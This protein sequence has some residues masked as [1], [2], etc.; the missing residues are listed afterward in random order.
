MATTVYLSVGDGATSDYLTLSDGTNYVFLPGT[1][2]AP[3]PV[4]GDQV[5]IVTFALDVL[6]STAD[7]MWANYRAILK[8]IRQAKQAAGA[9][10]RGTRVTLGVRMASATTM[11]YLDVIDGDAEIQPEAFDIPLTEANWARGVIVT[12]VCELYGRSASVALSVSGTITNDDGSPATVGGAGNASLYLPDIPGD[13]EAFCQIKLIDLSTGSTFLN[14]MRIGRRSRDAMAASTDFDPLLVATANSPG[15][16]AADATAIGGN[17]IRVTTTQAWQDL[18]DVAG[19]STGPNNSG[20]FDLW[21]IARNDVT[22][23]RPTLAIASQTS[24]SLGVGTFIMKVA[25]G[26]T[27]GSTGEA[28]DPVT[29]YTTAGPDDQFNLVTNVGG[30]PNDDVILYYKKGSAVWK[31]MPTDASGASTSF[32]NETSA[33]V[34]NPPTSSAFPLP[35]LRAQVGMSSGTTLYDLPAVSMSV[36]NSVWHPVYLGRVSLPPVPT[37]EGLTTERWKVTIQARSQNTTTPNADVCAMFLMP[38]DEP[39]M[40]ATYNGLALATLREWMLDSRRDERAFGILRSTADQTEQ[41]QLE[42]LGRMSL[43]PGDNLLI[44]LPEGS[45]GAM[46]TTLKWTATVT[47]FP[48]YASL[49]G[50]VT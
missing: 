34:G 16:S 11:V 46:A 22:I 7:G 12:L 41:G 30:L 24:G 35:Q 33:T 37:G 28:S 9:V 13:V 44:F 5:R 36:P 14:R 20:V 45:T 17:R 6:G 15:V 50:T 49:A 26:T 31:Y 18:A 2:S 3:T 1:F 43:M 23:I 39:Q 47:Y 38:A 4:D 40:T 27:H 8:K 29:G 10:G 21:V 42:V 25:N 32:G 48:R 19:A